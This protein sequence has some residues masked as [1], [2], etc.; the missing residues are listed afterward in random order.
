MAAR[1]V[2]SSCEALATKSCRIAFEPAE[3]GD[4][5]EDENR[6]RSRRTREGVATDREIPVVAAWAGSR[7]G[8]TS[9]PS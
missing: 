2:L 4:I 7:P 1:G 8:K 3:L 6:P 9:S 5:V